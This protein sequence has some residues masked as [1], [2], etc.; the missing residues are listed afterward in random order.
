MSDSRRLPSRITGVNMAGRQGLKFLRK[1]DD[2]DDSRDVK[3]V[4]D[5]QTNALFTTTAPPSDA[6][7]PFTNQANLIHYLSEVTQYFS[8]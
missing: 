5:R 8:E 3:S 2:A 7:M 1:E 6:G 4:V